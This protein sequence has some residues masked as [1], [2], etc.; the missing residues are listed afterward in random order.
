MTDEGPAAGADEG[1]RLGDS[2]PGH[3]LYPRGHPSAPF[4]VLYGPGRFPKK[5]AKVE[6]PNQIPMILQVRGA[7][8]CSGSRD[9]QV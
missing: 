4:L 8:T 6:M 3:S 2:H 5:N 1:Q 9:T 7:L